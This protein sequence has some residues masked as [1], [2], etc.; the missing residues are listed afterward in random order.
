M[1]I[2]LVVRKWILL[3]HRWTGV[4]FCALFFMWFASGI[5]MM[6]CEYPVLSTETRLRHLPALHPEEIVI[7]PSTAL[8]VANLSSPDQAV[9]TSLMG[10]PAYR[11]HRG[12]KISTIFADSG[13]P[14][15]GLSEP[16][17]RKIAADWVGLDPANAHLVEKQLEEDQWT[18]TQKYRAYRPL[19]VYG[20]PKGETVY[21]SDV[22]GEV[23][24]YTTRS[25][26]LGAY[27]GAIPHWIYFT[28]LRKDAANWS[29]TVIWLSAAG[30]AMTLL[31][32][33]AGIWL[34]SPSKKY[35]FQAGP[36]SV[37]FA[38]QKHWHVILGLLFGLSTFTWIL[39]G[40]FSMSI[41]KSRPE[42][43]QAMLGHQLTGGTWKGSDWAGFSPTSALRSVQNSMI[44]RE[45]EFTRFGD[46]PVYLAS[47]SALNSGLLLQNQA[48]AFM[49]NA[50]VL[51]SMIAS[52][53][54]PFHI[55]KSRT[56]TEYETY[57]VDRRH[58]KPLPALYILTDAPGSMA[59]YIDL[60]T[61]KIV[62]SYGA[63]ARWNRWLYHG[64]HSLDL[65]WLYRHRPLWDLIV[66]AFM[67][68]GMALSFT[69]VVIGYRRM[70]AKMNRMKRLLARM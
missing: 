7:D 25:S 37:P 32:I 5:V 56:I 26:R 1:R 59:F 36:S 35:R 41:L 8:H 16:I 50:D 67:A 53:I 68:G 30:V 48:P 20:W 63:K 42:P 23:V 64:L 44:V 49:Q 38:G 66:I 54:R 14:F 18:V 46:Q 57:Y 62:Q 70:R 51:K 47:E 29:K 11:L 69:G 15:S 33:I 2:S 45:L 3:V 12:N 24:Q 58:E 10:R 52:A 6:Y 4:A 21:V 34:Y 31:G 43:I 39:S 19:W 27:F 9:I 28:Q 60:H 61:A 55:T 65:P 22:T 40:M 13:I 17:A